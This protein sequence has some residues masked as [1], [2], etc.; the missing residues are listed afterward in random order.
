MKRFII[1]FT[2]LALIFAHPALAESGIGAGLIPG[3]CAEELMGK[4]SGLSIGGGL[5]APDSGLSIGRWLAPEILRP[6]DDWYYDTALALAGDAWYMATDTAY[7]SSH[8]LPAVTAHEIASAVDS[9]SEMHIELPDR[10]YR[11]HGTS[12]IIMQYMVSPDYTGIAGAS[13]DKHVH[14][15]LQEIRRTGMMQQAYAMQGISVY[16]EAITYFVL[17][18]SFLPQLIVLDYGGAYVS[19]QFLGLDGG[20]GMAAATL[21]TLAD[22]GSIEDILTEIAGTELYGEAHEI[23]AVYK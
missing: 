17:P 19:V 23:L 20:V 16:S 11:L 10:A 13:L 15:R 9:L 8:M 21:I 2:F 6:A 7:L 1:F 5:S 4:D 12:R 14:L 18:D 22:G 3:G